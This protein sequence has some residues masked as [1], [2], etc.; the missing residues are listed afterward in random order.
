MLIRQPYENRHDGAPQALV[1]LRFRR[2]SGVTMQV[3]RGY[4]G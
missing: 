4:A 1:V 2:H 3:L